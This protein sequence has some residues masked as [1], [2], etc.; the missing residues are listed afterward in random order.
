ML[1]K[2]NSGKEL[3]DRDRRRLD[4][5]EDARAPADFAQEQVQFDESLLGY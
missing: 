1:R 3:N 2:L 5:F 4:K